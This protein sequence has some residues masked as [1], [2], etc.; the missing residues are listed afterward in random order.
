MKTSISA[1]I[2]C[3]YIL[4]C[5]R[6]RTAPWKYFQLNARH[7]SSDKGIFS[8][9]N[10]DNMIPERWRLKQ[11]R[12]GETSAPT[13]FPIFVKP[14]WG[15]NANG[16]TRADDQ[17]SFNAIRQRLN[18]SATRYIAQQGAPERRE[19]EIYTIF[20]T[21]SRDH[22]ELITVTESIN[23]THDYPVNSIYNENTFYHDITD[24]FDDDQLLALSRHTLEIGQFG[25][26]RLSTRADN[27][28][29]LVAGRFHVIELNLFIPMPINL[30]DQNVSL[31]KRLAFI[32]RC[33]WT[34]ARATQAIDSQQKSQPIFTRM[35]L[36][37]R[38]QKTLGVLRSLL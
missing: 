3:V 24:Q 38:S 4:C 8:K 33:S 35:M 16:V 26:C 36:Y 5:L 27:L 30:L 12:L 13:G 22:C 19:F 17:A 7:F 29:D 28:D 37:G 9:L 6:L 2:V 31:S 21:A 34:L 14:E 20:P 1:L 11:E 10:I 32:G 15:Q 25:H 18:G 23:Q